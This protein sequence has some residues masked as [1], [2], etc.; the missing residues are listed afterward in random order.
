MKEQAGK[1]RLATA[2]GLV[3]RAFARPYDGNSGA[4]VLNLF[5]SGEYPDGPWTMFFEATYGDA[6]R[7]ELKE[8]VPGIV[9][10]L[11]NYVVA[12]YSS[13]AG[14]PELG[15]HVTIVDAHGEHKVPIEPIS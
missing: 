8:H 13:G 1:T 7:Y 10:F 4:R 11:V 3:Y 12:S 5:A 14:L 15:D 9:Y 2:D 6:N